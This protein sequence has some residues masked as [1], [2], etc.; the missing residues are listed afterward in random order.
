MF[1]FQKEH[2]ETV[3]I[4]VRQSNSGH[5]KWRPG[6]EVTPDIIMD[7]TALG[8]P[9][10]WFNLVVFDPPHML[11]LTETSVLRQKYGVLNDASWRY[12]LAQGFDEC[13][14]V[15]CHGGTLAFKWNEA[16]I[17]LGEVLKCFSE[18]PLFG[19]RQGKTIWLIFYKS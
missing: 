5:I 12:D 17:K 13:W 2:P 3:Y 14:R 1:W 9:T 18:E 11:T 19:N 10:D 7:F 6:H 15:L 4:D 8:F 16:E